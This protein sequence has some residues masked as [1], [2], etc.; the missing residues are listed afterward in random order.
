[1]ILL[2]IKVRKSGQE[3]TTP[4]VYT[5]DVTTS[6]SLPRRAAPPTNPAWYHNLVANPEATAEVGTDKSRCG[7]G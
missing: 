5:K 4:L 7:R 6:S 2:T 1:M 3:R